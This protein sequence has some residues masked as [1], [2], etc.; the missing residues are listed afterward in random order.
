MI[1][2]IALP[3]SASCEDFLN[4]IKTVNKMAQLGLEFC[5]SDSSA[6]LTCLTERSKSYFSSMH[7][8][9]MQVLNLMVE[10]ESWE[11]VNINLKDVGG[12]LGILKKSVIVSSRRKSKNVKISNNKSIKIFFLSGKCSYMHLIQRAEKYNNHHQ[13][14]T[15]EG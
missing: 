12:V 11:V 10:S 1:A 13:S 8:E 9:A 7:I 6:L 4:I 2:S 3:S 5:G 15:N 14:Q